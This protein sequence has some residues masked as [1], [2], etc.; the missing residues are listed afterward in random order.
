MTDLIDLFHGLDDKCDN[1]N[2]C[3]GDTNVCINGRCVCGAHGARCSKTNP[4][5][6]HITGI[7]QCGP[8]K[9]KW[10]G[11]DK[12]CFLGQ[13]CVIKDEIGRCADT[14]PGFDIK[15]LLP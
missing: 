3:K 1:H 6:D 12:R 14:S 8:R 9:N 11:P 2:N 10:G 13:V 4:T 15:Y 5:C 7:C